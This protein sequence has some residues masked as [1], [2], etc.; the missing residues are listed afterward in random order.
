MLDLLDLVTIGLGARRGD[1]RA[2]AVRGVGADGLLHDLG[3]AVL[4]GGLDGLLADQDGRSAGA[5]RR[6]AVAYGPVLLA[7]V[8]EALLLLVGG[9]WLGAVGALRV[10]RGRQVLSLVAGRACATARRVEGD[11]AACGLALQPTLSIEERSAVMDVVCAGE[12]RVGGQAND[13]PMNH[14]E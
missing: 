9:A 5:A 8:T 1:W 2:G 3:V 14:V 4:L 10:A 11:A 7:L 12:S 13:L 6:R